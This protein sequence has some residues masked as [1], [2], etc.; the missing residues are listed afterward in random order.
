MKIGLLSDT[1][2]YLPSAVQTVFSDVDL[3]LH[4]G[5]IGNMEILDRLKQIAPVRAVYGNTDIYS[6]AS[7]LPSRI[8]FTLEGLRIFLIHNIGSVKNFSW[9]I[10]RGDFPEPP[11]MVVYGHTHHAS[12]QKSGKC[13]FINP[14]SAGQP[15]RGERPTVMKIEIKTKKLVGHQIINLSSG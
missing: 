14:G 7:L 15:R 10:R 9:R 1:H 6:I 2:N 8:F 5:D 11:D 12:F 13:Y 3:I 4:A